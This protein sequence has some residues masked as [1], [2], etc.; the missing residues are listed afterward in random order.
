MADDE[1]RMLFDTRGKRKHVIRVVYAIL[2]LL[3]GASLFLVVGPFNLAELTG[4]SSGSSASEVFEEQAERIEGRLA[5]N[6]DDEQLLLALTRAHINAGNAQVDVT[7]A[8]EPTALSL[9]AQTAFAAAAESWN[10]YLK[11]AGDEPS[12]S[13]A[14]LVAG[15][16]FR[17]AEVGS[18]SLPELEANVDQAVSAQRIAAEQRPSVGAFSNL[19]IYEYF[20]FD[21]AAG[22][23]AKKEAA[24]LAASKAEAKAIE[25]QLT[26]YSK[27]AK[28]F[29]KRTQ[30][31]ARQEQ[32]TGKEALETPFG[33]GGG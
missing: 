4:G 33:L 13:G 19:A 15:T 17:L 18:T 21:F 23:K 31:I 20:A 3:M 22:E 7:S 30:R 5:K 8:A 28:Q 29:Q 26:S 6:P 2:A 24:A 12:P 14:Q 11:Q 32:R 10:R 16:F 1:R 9:E 27:R 25:N